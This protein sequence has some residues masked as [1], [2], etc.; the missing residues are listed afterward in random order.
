MLAGAGTSR[1][2]PRRRSRDLETRTWCEARGSTSGKVSGVSCEPPTPSMRTSAPGGSDT[3][4]SVPR[5]SLLP[6]A[7]MTAATAPSA[8]TP[9]MATRDVDAVA[10]LRAQRLASGSPSGRLES[11]LP[12][13]LSSPSSRPGTKRPESSGGGCAGG[14]R[15]GSSNDMR[16]DGLGARP[17]DCATAAWPASRRRSTPAARPRESAAPSATAGA[18]D[19][20]GVLRTRRDRRSGASSAKLGARRSR[21]AARALRVRCAV[22]ASSRSAAGAF[23]LRDRRHRRS[24]DALVFTGGGAFGW[25]A[26]PSGVG[27]ACRGTA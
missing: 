16:T 21:L 8:M 9:R 17:A 12:G 26:T 3:M 27:R 4:L 6:P 18:P 11:A 14:M 20:A 23:G 15:V 13:S 22:S 1:P 2:T 19:C 7:N 10:T 25:R 5:P 24:V